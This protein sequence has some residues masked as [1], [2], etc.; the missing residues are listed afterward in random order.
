[1]CIQDELLFGTPA[2]RIG[3]YPS[4]APDV[5]YSTM[6]LRSETFKGVL[7]S[8]ALLPLNRLLLVGGDSGNISL[9][10]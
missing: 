4:I 2:N 3:I 6:K 9:L 8:L 5:S 7:T 1:M 10:C